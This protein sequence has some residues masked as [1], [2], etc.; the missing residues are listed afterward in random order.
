MSRNQA[1]IIRGTL[2]AMLG[3]LGQLGEPPE[4]DISVRIRDGLQVHEF[5]SF[6]LAAC[7]DDEDGQEE[8]RQDGREDKPGRGRGQPQ[9][10]ADILRT[11]FEVAPKRLT[12]TKLIE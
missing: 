9:C 5:R 2:W 11:L 7:D 1:R 3:Q 8:R 10:I 6:S 4:G 12:I